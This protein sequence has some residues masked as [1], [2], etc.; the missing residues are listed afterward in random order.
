MF[1]NGER[2]PPCMREKIC[3]DVNVTEKNFLQR[4]GEDAILTA[5]TKANPYR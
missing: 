5:L 2:L 1:S 4:G 3:S